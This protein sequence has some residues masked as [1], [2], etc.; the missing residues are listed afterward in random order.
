MNPTRGLAL[1]K[2]KN[3]NRPVVTY[4]RYRELLKVAPKVRVRVGAG[5][6]T[7][8][9]RAPLRELLILAEG[10]GRRIGALVALRW[11]DW[12][13]DRVTSGAIRWRADSDK[14]GREWVAPVSREVRQALE[15]WRRECP[16]VGEAPMFPQANHVDRCISVYHAR[17]WLRDAERLVGLAP[18]RGGLWH[19]F[20][21]KWAMER[22]GLELRDVAF[23]GGWKD[24]TTLLRVYQQPDPE[25]LE[26]VVTEPRKLR[27]VAGS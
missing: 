25:T 16:G 9:V 12:L 5:S 8:Y 26:R 11:S 2:E 24:P 23:A 15:A 13:S 7:E 20:R 19:T 14:L 3:P 6:R 22:K 21:R 18:T 4:D 27:D 10:T 1:P 17:N